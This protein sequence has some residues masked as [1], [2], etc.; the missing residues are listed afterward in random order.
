MRISV[1]V[2]LILIRC[3]GEWVNGRGRRRQK[4]NKLLLVTR[5]QEGSIKLLRSSSLATLKGDFHWFLVFM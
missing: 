2:E 4:K 1:V 5:I 3:Q